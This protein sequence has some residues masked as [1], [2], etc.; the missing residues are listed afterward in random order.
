M[1]TGSWTGGALGPPWTTERGSAGAHQSA[2]SPVLRGSDPCHNF[3]RRER[4]TMGSPP[5]AALGGGV[6]EWGR[7]R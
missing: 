3:T 2:G 7:W 1:S 4:R 6:T 5:R